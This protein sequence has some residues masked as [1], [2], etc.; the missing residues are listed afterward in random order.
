MS[1]RRWQD[2]FLPREVL[3]PNAN[4]VVLRQQLPSGAPMGPSRV[5]RGASRLAPQ[6]QRALP[7]PLFPQ[8]RRGHRALLLV[9]AKPQHVARGP[10]AA[11]RVSGLRHL[12]WHSLGEQ[13]LKSRACRI[14]LRFRA[15][16]LASGGRHHY[17]PESWGGRRLAARRQ[18]HL[19]RSHL[20]GAFRE[21]CGSRPSSC[22]GSG[23]RALE[24]RFQ[25]PGPHMQSLRA[26]AHCAWEERH[27]GALQPRAAALR[28]VLRAEALRESRRHA[29]QLR[30]VDGRGH[31]H[32]AGAAVLLLARLHLPKL[33]GAAGVLRL[34]P[35]PAGQ[36]HGGGHG[37]HSAHAGAD[38]P[39]RHSDHGKPDGPQ[40]VFLSVPAAP[41][42]IDGVEGSS[43]HTVRTSRRLARPHSQPSSLGRIG[44]IMDASSANAD[45][46]GTIDRMDI[47]MDSMM[48]RNS[49]AIVGLDGLGAQG[50]GLQSGCCRGD[51]LFGMAH[52]LEVLRL[53]VQTASKEGHCAQLPQRALIVPGEGSSPRTLES[54][55]CC[56]AAAARP[57]SAGSAISCSLAPCG[58]GRSVAVGCC[59]FF[60]GGM[61]AI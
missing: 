60:G 21:S 54:T 28:P 47:T 14:P 6:P 61:A 42:D 19:Q 35:P 59:G 53:R 40:S 2:G 57:R 10:R 52:D 25:Q 44:C 3:I 37:G 46:G 16:P 33:G 43:M 34:A 38:G 32:Q 27:R 31:P 8:Q 39:R 1:S 4:P 18:G 12:S 55:L 11:R 56:G 20:S 48:P 50:F 29:P 41:G 13:P 23:S 24:R 49:K 36:G 30:L 26:D 17:G 5:G 45:S 7:R 15:A 58:I 22:W 51:F 9:R